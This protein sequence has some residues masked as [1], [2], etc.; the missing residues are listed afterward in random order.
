M[1]FHGDYFTGDVGDPVTV[2]M[3]DL[4]GVGG[5]RLGVRLE[6]RTR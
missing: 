3:G 2:G 1:V 6:W 5:Y 4:V